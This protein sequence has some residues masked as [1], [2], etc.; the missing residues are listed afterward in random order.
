LFEEEVLSDIIKN[1]KKYIAEIVP[2][3][4][5]VL[6]NPT[7]RYFESNSGIIKNTKK[8][9]AEIVPD[10]DKVLI[11]PTVRYFESNSGIDSVWVDD[12]VTIYIPT[13]SAYDHVDAVVRI[14]LKKQ[15]RP[16]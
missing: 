9:I 2:D 8:Y 5:K 14:D 6:I 4:D 10:L 7:V 1:T 11:N 15:G 3:L 16:S 12:M 13:D